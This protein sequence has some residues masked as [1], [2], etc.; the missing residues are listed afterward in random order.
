MAGKIP[1]E[2]HH[3]TGPDAGMLKEVLQRKLEGIHILPDCAERLLAADPAACPVTTGEGSG[4]NILVRGTPLY[5]GPEVL[6]RVQ[7]DVAGLMKDRDPRHVIF[8]GY[9]LGLHLKIL[10]GLTQAPIIVFDPDSEAVASALGQLPLEIP[11]LYLTTTPEAL[12]D[13]L[14]SLLTGRTP[15]L[16]VGALPASRQLHPEAFATFQKLV[17]DCI[18]QQNLAKQ[19]IRRFSLAWLRN[20]AANLPDVGRQK[21]FTVL[22]DRFAGKPAIFVGAGPSLD[23]NLEAL[24]RAKGQ[25]LIM[26]AHTAAIPLSAAGVTPDAIIIIEGQKL[27]GYFAGAD[28]LADTVL[29]PAPR[30]H[31]V[32]LTLGFKD[33]LSFT[34]EGSVDADWLQAAYGQAPLH[35]GGSVACSA[36][37]VLQ[38]LG[39]DPL[40]CVGMDFAFSNG[41]S[42]AA[43]SEFGCC[44]IEPDKEE[45]TVLAH[46][47]HAKKHS[48]RTYKVDQVAAWGGEGTVPARASFSSF[49]HWFEGS[50]RS[51][52]S[53]NTLINANGVGARIRGFTEMTLDEVLE[54]YCTEPVPAADLIDEALAAAEPRDPA[55]LLQAVAAELDIIAAASQAAEKAIAQADQAIAKLRRG[56]LH[57]VQPFLDQVAAREQEL[58][59]LTLRTRLLNTLVGIRADEI[60]SEP[61]K[62]D[63]VKKT[64]GS[65]ELSNTI[66]ALVIKGAREL[67]EQFGPVVGWE[68]SAETK[69]GP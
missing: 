55:L 66:S 48:E 40:I 37:A 20:L 58:R 25:A 67:L 41:R 45:G 50:A 68:G 31:P 17:S 11:D 28:T 43:G 63:R 19:T 6:P 29:L 7:A 22:G 4:P 2:G 33:Y 61:V 18:D 64:I 52:L 36:F 34:M 69:S 39:C 65:L 24:A 8:F 47:P 5:A 57:G 35:A 62:G 23:D 15:Q 32:H 60:A 3:M 12:T 51:W 16:V 56:Q 27:D 9:G 13:T 59:E 38:A 46:C 49:R 10:R 30:T 21:P 42:H 53:G 1:R 44:V 14:G 54:R 26:A